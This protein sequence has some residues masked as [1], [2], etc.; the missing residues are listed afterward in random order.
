MK[1]IVSVEEAYLVLRKAIASLE[2]REPIEDALELLLRVY[3][4]VEMPATRAYPSM[5]ERIGR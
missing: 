5:V 1:R 2:Q 3:D 4:F